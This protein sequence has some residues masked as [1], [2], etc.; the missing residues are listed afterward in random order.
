MG[1]YNG[2]PEVP[3]AVTTVTPG[4]SHRLR[5]INQSM[6]NVF[7]FSIDGHNLTVRTPLAVHC[8]YK[9]VL[10]SNETQV[11]EVDGMPVQ[12]LTVDKLDLLAGQRYSVIVR[13]IL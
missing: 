9:L 1:R 4:L 12:P 5:I 13:F 3:W 11:I 2:G 6:R 7:T 8:I 10:T